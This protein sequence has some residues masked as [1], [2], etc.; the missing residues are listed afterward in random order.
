MDTAEHARRRDILM[1]HVGED[2]IAVLA[3]APER[4][5]NRDVHHPYRQDSDFLYLSGFDEPDAV[6]VLVP[7]RAQGEFILFSRERDPLR[8]TWEGRTIGQA[9]A[10]EDYGADDAFPIDDIDDILPGLMEG[11]DKVYCAMGADADFDQRLIGW[12]NALRARARAGVRAPLEYVSLEHV[13]HE[14]RLIKSKAEVARMRESARI[15]AA[16]HA[17]LL[18]VVRPG[19]MEY[20]VEAELLYDFRRHNGGP[21]YPIIAGGGANACVLHYIANQAALQDGD[22]LLVDA[23]IELDGY[24]ADIT[25]TL[26]VNGR[27][28]G[29]QRAIY[30]L[31]LDA[32]H[33]ALAEV[34]PGQHWNA[35]H[36]AATR[37]LVE[38]MVEL[39]LLRGE[40][41]ELIESGDY[42]R[43]FMHRT[44][45]WLGMDVHDVGDY[46]VDGHWRELEPGMA[47]T[48]EPGL[49][50]PPGSPVDERWHGIGV[51]IEDN[52]VITRDGHD[53]LTAAAPKAIDDIEAAMVGS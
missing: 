4:P 21:A 35:A 10:V 32:Q 52:C 18:G 17:R 39:D 20:E 42:R 11:R 9:A 14:M 29:E 31:V 45:H 24:A 22:L 40:V 34:R 6:A 36:E 13:L 26:P 44:G 50:I 8:E 27:F 38:G 3:A 43:F 47:L 23:G 48:V 16:A 41:D 2:G 28:S 12:V 5:R 1:R 33:A 49:Y 25:R 30:E 19:L 15:T 53:N 7:G 51:R 37:I 46:K